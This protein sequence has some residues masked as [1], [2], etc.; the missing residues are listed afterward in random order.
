MSFY[1]NYDLCGFKYNFNH[2]EGI[3]QVLP[4]S[5]MLPQIQ[6]K[7]FSD[8]LVQFNCQTQAPV[9]GKGYHIFRE[10]SPKLTIN[11]YEYAHSFFDLDFQSDED[12]I[13]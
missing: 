5:T 10:I 8:S 11:I 2:I 9:K 12:A 6:R 1:C 3:S 7:Y 13:Q 4:T